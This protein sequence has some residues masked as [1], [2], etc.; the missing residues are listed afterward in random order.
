MASNFLLTSCTTISSSPSKIFVRPKR[1]DNFKVNCEIRNSNTINNDDNEGKSFPGKLDRRNVLLGLGGLYGASN[2]IGV[3]NEPFALGAPVPPPDFSTCS[4]AS[5]PDGSQVPFSC[6]PPLPKDLTNIPTY[7]LPNVSKVKI[8]P[9]AHNVTQ[10]YITKYNTAI[11]KMKS[12]DKDDPLSFIQQANIHCAYCNS[13]YKELGFPGVPLQVHFSWLFFPFHRWYL[14][15]FERILGSLIG[16]DT[17]ALP[18]WNY[19]SQVGMQFPS[20]YNDVNSSLYDPNRNQNHFPPNVIDLG[21]TTIDLDAS[22]QQKINNNLTMM[23]RQML[24][25]APCPQLFFGNPIRGGEQPIRGMGTIENVPHNSVHRW[26]GNPNNKFRENMGTFYSAARDP[27]FYAHHAN[28]DRMWTIWKTLGGNRRDFNDRD[29]LDSAFL[30]YDENRTLV[31]V[32]VQDCINNEKLGYKYEN[33]PIPWKNYKPVPRK[34]KLKKN[35]KNV[36]PSTEIFPSTLKKTLSFSIKRPKISRTQQDKDIEEELLVFN[37]MTFDE[38]EYIR[39]DVFINEDEGVKSKVL[40]RTEYVGSFANLPHVHAAGNNTGSS[41]S[42]GSTPAVMSLGI[43]E[44]LE[45]LGL[46]DEEEIVVVVV[47]QFGG[48]EITIA[49]VE[50]D[51]LACAN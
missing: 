17:F 49:S 26:V 48:K 38:N 3:T 39:F 11:Q 15:F 2:L 10:E 35:P 30:F 32:T 28:V 45:D 51:T 16:D 4:T 43:S 9:A 8:R 18:F 22:D 13:G 1:I 40:D 42:S 20:L 27:I 44:I 47:P 29:W 50:I 34:Q 23:Y 24:T 19:D 5:L 37:N 46:E 21:F 33:V 7:K 14:Y 12:L 25:N 36:K 41:S 31:K 6:C